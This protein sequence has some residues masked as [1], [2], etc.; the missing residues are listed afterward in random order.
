[1]PALDR[2][3]T[4]SLHGGTGLRA[5]GL[6]D[7]GE[8]ENALYAAESSFSIEESSFFSRRVFIFGATQSHHNVI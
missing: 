5:K 4:R 7:E 2:P 1:M 6:E 8:Y 3:L